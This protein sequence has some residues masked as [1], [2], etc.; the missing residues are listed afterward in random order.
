ME[1]K[2]NSPERE[3]LF[4][5]RKSAEILA[6]LLQAPLYQKHAIVKARKVIPGERVETI[7]SSGITETIKTG[8]EGDWLV[9]NPTGEQFVLDNNTF[10]SRNIATD[11]EGVYKAVGYCKAVQNPYGKAIEI[12]ASWGQAQ[13]GDANCYIADTCGE[14]GVMHGEPYIIERRAFVDTYQEVED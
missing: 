4:I 8:L 10:T 9:T 7:T 12:M 13:Y 1:Y 6:L 14:D 5:E 3:Y 2:Q 11:T